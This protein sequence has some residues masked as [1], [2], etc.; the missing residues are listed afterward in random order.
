MNIVSLSSAELAERVVMVK[1]VRIM[2][3]HL[4]TVC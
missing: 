4:D 3:S 1:I 2:T